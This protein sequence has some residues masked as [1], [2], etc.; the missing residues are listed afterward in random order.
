MDNKN[1]EQLSTEEKHDKRMREDNVWQFE[2]WREM[3]S[4][5]REGDQI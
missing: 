2:K 4:G 1:K 5:L 3:R